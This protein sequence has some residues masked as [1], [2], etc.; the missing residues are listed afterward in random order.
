MPFTIYS[1]RNGSLEK[2][3]HSSL[4]N[5]K[6]L[7]NVLEAIDLDGDGD[8]DYIAGNQGIN[9]D[10]KASPTKP[11]KLYA[12]DFDQN[13]KIDP[14]LA[15]FIKDK[16]GGKEK[17]FPFHGMDDLIK[18][19]VGFRKLFQSYQQY[20]EAPFD[21]LLTDKMLQ[22]A[23]VFEAQ[24]LVSTYFVNLGNGRFDPIEL[25][26]EAQ[27]APIR[28]IVTE[29][30]NKDGLIDIIVAGNNNIAENTY[31]SYDASLG[32]ALLNENGHNFQPVP[33]YQSGLFLSSD[34]RSM[35][36][37]NT[38][39]QGELLLIGVNN[40]EAICLKKT[41]NGRA[42]VRSIESNKD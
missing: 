41:T 33:A 34:V 8:N 27:V 15:H 7:W 29:D 5:T 28:A 42:R 40:D 24:T 4:K 16:I 38:K 12:D 36:K 26:I 18:Q 2:L 14:I 3:E 21:Q 6:G 32:L 25:P 23:Q 17:L 19:V 11:L 22:N 30:L 9:Q 10:F 1:N 13:G 37:I 31:G 35:A 39:N 20:S